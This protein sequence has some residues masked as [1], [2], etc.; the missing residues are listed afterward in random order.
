MNVSC[1]HTGTVRVTEPS[2]YACEDCVAAG[3]RDWLHLRLCTACGHVGCCDQSPGR[4]A[5]KHFVAKAH[6]IIRSIERD[7]GWYWC[8]VD[9]VFLGVDLPSA[10]GSRR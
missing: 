7:E 8:Y 9:E 6:P 10:A 4:H 3:R 5:T 2:A 1:S